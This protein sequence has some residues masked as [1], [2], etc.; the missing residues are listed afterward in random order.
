MSTSP[1]SSSTSST[2]IIAPASYSGAIPTPRARGRAG[3][4]PPYDRSRLIG[5]LVI[6]PDLSAVEV[7]D[8]PAQR[9]PDAGARISVAGM[10]PLEDHE[11][12][13]AVGRLDPDP[14]VLAGELPLTIL[15]PGRDPDHRR[16]VHPPELDRV[17]DQVREQLDEQPAL[18]RYGGQPVDRDRRVAVL[19]GGFQLRYG[20][21][22]RL[23][24]VDLAEVRAWLPDPRERQQVVDQA[25]HPLGA[26]DRVGDVLLGP[27]VELL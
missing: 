13:V 4:R 3:Q 24:Q 10:Q 21:A 14:V 17:A 27:L 1:G 23:I 15:L 6:D 11:Y 5:L 16:R 20:A 18:A 25:L 22:G 12:P 19:D 2:W 9:E 7:D 8:L 26:V